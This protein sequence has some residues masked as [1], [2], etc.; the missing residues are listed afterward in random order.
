MVAKCTAGSFIF[1][2]CS[3]VTVQSHEVASFFSGLP[4]TGQRNVATGET[5]LAEGEWSATRG[6]VCKWKRFLRQEAPRVPLR[7]TR[8]YIP[9]PHPGRSDRNLSRFWREAS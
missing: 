6:R 8:G 1:W 4:R 2:I 5:T 3:V 9:T 7:S